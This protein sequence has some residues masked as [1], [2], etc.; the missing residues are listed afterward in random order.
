MILTAHQYLDRR[1]SLFVFRILI[2]LMCMFTVALVLLYFQSQNNKLKEISRWVQANRA[3][4]EE[5]VFLENLHSVNGILDRA[6][7]VAPGLNLKIGVF[8]TAGNHLAGAIH[9]APTHLV[10][11]RAI[12]RFSGWIELIEP[13]QFGGRDLGYVVIQGRVLPSEL[14][15]HSI[16]AF[17]TVFVLFVLYLFVLR[18]F[19]NGVREKILVPLEILKRQMS[20]GRPVDISSLVSHQQVELTDEI[21]AVV[22]AYN[23]LLVRMS[24]KEVQMKELAE[25]AA[26]AELAKQLAHDIRSPLSALNMVVSTFSQLDEDR[27]TLIRNASQ[28]IHD[29][30]NSLLTRSKRQSAEM[31]AV[32]PPSDLQMIVG[33]VEVIASEKCMEYMSRSGIEFHVDLS[34]GYGAFARVDHAEFGRS[35]SNL[36]NNA[37][38]SI[39][40]NGVIDISVRVFGEHIGVTV[41]DNGCGM[42]EDLLQKI[43]K[44]GFSS[45]KS[46]GGSGSGIGLYQVKEMLAQS[47]GRLEVWSKEGIGT[48]I[49]MIL[50][51]EGVPSWFV[52]KIKLVTKTTVVSIDDDQTIHQLWNEKLKLYS[53]ENPHLTHL[54]FTSM[55]AAEKW[56]SQ[57]GEGG[58]LNCL[59]LVDYTF[60]GEK[61]NGLDFIEKLSIAEHSI[62]V[63]SRFEEKAVFHQ[64]EKMGVRI[65]PKS[66][67]PYVPIELPVYDMF[68]YTPTDLPL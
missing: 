18:S 13:L 3:N 14:I 45:G 28:R 44:K 53:R 24:E 61:S 48:T 17:F 7:A 30:A 26:T 59:F 57:L 15:L 50:P 22:Q 21:S 60:V 40:G 12:H 56:I 36:I 49:S 2:A 66:L 47:Q 39:S 41:R 16:L 4:I 62:L 1:L 64:A 34:Q 63:T 42:S 5:A 68:V 37:V 67:A 43:G 55:D 38:E 35:L 6:V 23:S 19:S 10:G 32:T 51:R 27:R 33:L 52:D 54:T 20:S 11:Y 25:I 9:E 29:I 31:G 8:S 46:E 58:L 65:I